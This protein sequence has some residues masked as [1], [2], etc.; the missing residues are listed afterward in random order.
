MSLKTIDVKL[1]T[2]QSVA[3]LDP[4]L[5]KRTYPYFSVSRI[6]S[7]HQDSKVIF[8]LHWREL[9]T[10]FFMT[11]FVKSVVSH[12]TSIAKKDIFR[13]TLYRV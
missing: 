5:T 6:R 12:A 10:M 8:A 1:D 13:A 7:E 9:S 4:Y 3:D 11:R 2:L